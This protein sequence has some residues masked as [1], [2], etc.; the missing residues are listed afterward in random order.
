MFFC[1]IVVTG[2]IVFASVIQYDYEIGIEYPADR[3]TYDYINRPS[4]EEVVDGYDYNSFYPIET[5][6]YPYSYLPEEY[7]IHQGYTYTSDY[8]VY[9]EHNGLEGY[10][11]YAG[12]FGYAPYYFEIMPLSF[13]VYANNI[14]ELRTHIYNAPISGELQIIYITTNIAI[15]GLSGTAGNLN[16]LG[17]DSFRESR[18]LQVAN[19]RNILIMSDPDAGT[20]FNLGQAVGSNYHFVVENGATLRLENI[21]LQRA[22]TGN[23][24]SLPGTGSG[25]RSGGIWVTTGGTAILGNGA[26][27]RGTQSMSLSSGARGGRPHLDNAGGGVMVNGTNAHFIMEEGSRIHHTRGRSSGG[28][29]AVTNNGTFTMLGGSIDNST[30]GNGTDR[31]GGVAVSDRGTF[32]MGDANNPSTNPE[33]GPRIHSNYLNSGAVGATGG[34]VDVRGAGST[35]RMYGG[36]IG[37]YVPFTNVDTTP[38][39]LQSFNPRLLTQAN[40]TGNGANRAGRGGGAS[41]DRGGR[42]YLNGGHIAGNTATRATYAGAGLHVRRATSFVTMDGG[43]I[44]GNLA[45]GSGGGV[46]VDRGNFIMHSGGINANR[47]NRFRANGGGGGVVNRGVFIMHGGQINHNYTV[48]SG[49]GMRMRNSGS[50]IMHGGE[51]NHNSANGGGGVLMARAGGGVVRFDM[52]GGSINHNVSRVSTTPTSTLRNNSATRVWRENGGGVLIDDGTFHIRGNNNKS[53]SYNA[54]RGTTAGHGSGGGIY[55]FGSGG[56]LNVASNEGLV[57]I[58]GNS[59]D[60]HGGGIHIGGAGFNAFMFH[61]T[62]NSAMAGGG[63]HSGDAANNHTM[64]FYYC[65]IDGNI[66]E[67]S[68]A[69]IYT[70]AGIITFENSTLSNNTAAIRGGGIYINP[71][72][73]NAAHIRLIDSSVNGNRAGTIGGGI[74]PVGTNSTV[75]AYNS[76]INSNIAGHRGGG[77]FMLNGNITLNGSRLNENLAGVDI[78]T[79]IPTTA[80][81]SGGGGIFITSGN[82]TL[83]NTEHTLDGDTIYLYDHNGVESVVIVSSYIMSPGSTTTIASVDIS[84]ERYYVDGTINTVNYVTRMLTVRDLFPT[85]DETIFFQRNPDRII[86]GESIEIDNSNAIFQAPNATWPNGR[87]LVGEVVNTSM[88]GVSISTGAGTVTIDGEVFTA[89]RHYDSITSDFLFEVVIIPAAFG[90]PLSAVFAEEQFIPQGVYG[91]NTAMLIIPTVGGNANNP[92]HLVFVEEILHPGLTP[93]GYISVVLVEEEDDDDGGDDD[94]ERIYMIT[95]ATHHFIDGINVV[96]TGVSVD[97]IG[98]MVDN[99]YVFVIYDE[100][101]LIVR[102]RRIYTIDGESIILDS[103]NDIVT[104]VNQVNRNEALMGGGIFMLTGGTLTMNNGVVRGNVATG[105]LF[106]GDTPDNTMV[107]HDT[108]HGGGGIYLAGRGYFGSAAGFPAVPEF[109]MYGG[110]IGDN[111]AHRGGGVF[112]GGG[113]GNAGTGTVAGGRFFMN[114]GRIENNFATVNGGGVFLAGGRRTVNT[115]G[116]QGQGSVFTMTDGNIVGNRSGSS[117]GGVFVQSGWRVPGTTGTGD[118]QS[119]GALFNMIGGSIDGNRAGFRADRIYD[120]NNPEDY[121]YVEIVTD[122]NARGGGVYLQGMTVNENTGTQNSITTTSGH[123]LI[124]RSR[125]NITGNGAIINNVA[126]GHGGGVFVGGGLRTGG[127]STGFAQGGRFEMTSGSISGN[128]SLHGDGG[129]LYLMGNTAP[130]GF[131]PSNAHLNNGDLANNATNAAAVQDNAASFLRIDGNAVVSYNEAPNGRGGG[132]FIDGGTRL[133]AG[134]SDHVVRGGKVYITGNGDVR[135]N[136]ARYGGGLYV[137]GGLREGTGT[138]GADGGILRI[139]VTAAHGLGVGLGGAVSGNTAMAYFYTGGNDEVHSIGGYGG[140]ILLRPGRNTGNDIASTS[141]SNPG[142]KFSIHGGRITDNTAYFDGGGIWISN[143]FVCDDGNNY[144]VAPIISGMAHDS[145]YHTTVSALGGLRRDNRR[146]SHAY[147]AG[148]TARYGNGG[149]IWFAPGLDLILVNSHVVANTAGNYGGSVFVPAGDGNF[150]NANLY[151]F[152]G[153]ISGDAYKGGGVFVQGGYGEDGA[154]RTNPGL[155]EMRNTNDMAVNAFFANVT[156]APPA[157]ATIH[158]VAGQGGGTGIIIPASSAPTVGLPTISTRENGISV[159]GGGLYIQGGTMA[160]NAGIFNWYNGNIGANG[161]NQ[162]GYIRGNRAQYGGGIF[163]GNNRDEG[164]NPVFN[165]RGISARS[166]VGNQ[167]TYAGGGLYISDTNVLAIPSTANVN[168]TDNRV[169]DGDGG[170]VYVALH[171]VL[172]AGNV[173]FYRNTAYNMGGAIFT[174]RL[175]YRDPLFRVRPSFDYTYEYELSYT[176]LIFDTNVRFDGNRASTE[177]QPPINATSA[178]PWANNR[179]TSQLIS[180]NT[181]HPLNNYDIN[182]SLGDSEDFWFFKTDYMLYHAANPSITLMP[183]IRFR[184]FRTVAELAVSAAPNSEVLFDGAT[185]ASLSPEW[186]EVQFA[187]GNYVAT[188]TNNNAILIEISPKYAYQLVQVSVQPGFMPPQGQWQITFCPDKDLLGDPPFS[189]LSIGTFAPV[190]VRS[191]DTSMIPASANHPTGDTRIV[192]APPRDDVWYVGSMPEF[193]LPL[194]G[195]SGLPLYATAGVVLTVCGFILVAFIVKKRQS[196]F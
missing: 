183:G 82:I 144:N 179:P 35:F 53:I 177:E 109:R 87:V 34:G 51:I 2:I 60:R 44:H 16:P 145:L 62:N 42:I 72:G 43:F 83:N 116:G 172:N 6:N 59:A 41:V 135:G 68:G 167:A 162:A 155:F 195:G 57:I 4:Y 182:F 128:I 138:G 140:G 37:V 149:G 178:I 48:N 147:I 24:G 85:D 40:L 151:M 107:G 141:V 130:A 29:V 27:I 164:Q 73:S 150:N 47:S 110:V 76:N 125:F 96:V 161:L 78:D 32:I 38:F 152:G 94:D 114:G 189:V 111:H 100:Q 12:Y 127:G 25:N 74:M 52:Y 117:G 132:V 143:T 67:T 133:G 196:R 69:G 46:L 23:G 7:N 54:A 190:F 3:Y 174:E 19:G 36:V 5:F 181:L 159:Y 93:N 108:P 139:G 123:T 31:G 77:I 89:G 1:L 153:Y 9:E 61:I 119:H 193:E 86:F 80:T 91:G 92:T 160:N 171:A 81:D 113:F 45:P 184:L 101:H 64:S 98:R 63:I 99:V 21:V 26:T 129:G 22:A 163:L 33:F 186:V 13:P 88:D 136:T 118:G 102:L 97:G 28:G 90:R 192:P 10:S 146:I 142:A 115:G 50:L 154:T 166:I 194:T 169:L 157:V 120:Y 176:N 84:G 49:G 175:E 156:G 170:G 55:W 121:E 30:P 14:T 126:N 191:S 105:Q 75:V 137:A 106:G 124:S 134:T 11:N 65:H 112:V 122:I 103:T 148:N 187:C 56:N 104:F 71:T 20:I 8:N 70:N 95:I 66:S 180:E 17:N 188:S 18:I 131:A 173:G 158:A 79:R 185:G 15:T 165:I 58:N 39:S 168:I